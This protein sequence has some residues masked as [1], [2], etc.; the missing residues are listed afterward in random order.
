MLFEIDNPRQ[1]ALN[2]RLVQEHL[3]WLTTVFPRGRPAPSLVWFLWQEEDLLVYS[4]DTA[5]V[6]NIESHPAVGF[7]LNSNDQGG[8]VLVINGVAR[9]DPSLPR[10]DELPEYVSKY[11]DRI[12]RLGMT[13]QTFADRYHIPI[14]I[15]PETYRAG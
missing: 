8:D 15:T 1:A 11:A 6:S 10:A 5:R 14:R 12:G 3:G 4:Q 9:A 2:D 13:P 7:N